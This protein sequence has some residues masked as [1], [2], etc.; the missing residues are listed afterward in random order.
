M[1]AMTDQEWLDIGEL[2]L[3]RSPVFY[4]VITIRNKNQG[5]LDK[6]KFKP[7]EA[8]KIFWDLNTEWLKRLEIKDKEKG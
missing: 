4:Y 7:D 3:D 2:E 5:L 1:G 8:E 6:M